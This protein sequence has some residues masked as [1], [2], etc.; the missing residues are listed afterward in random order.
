MTVLGP[1]TLK[2]VLVMYRGESFFDL[3]RGVHS[4]F[5]AGCGDVPDTQ[6]EIHGWLGCLRGPWYRPKFGG[7]EEGSRGRRRTIC[8]VDYAVA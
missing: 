7:I 1:K 6:P 5:D 8:L 4:G 2:L 3:V